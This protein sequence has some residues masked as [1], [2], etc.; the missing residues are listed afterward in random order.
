M[1]GPIAATRDLIVFDQRGI[2]L[3]HPLSCHRFELSA[4]GPALGQQIAECAAQIGP[5]RS[6]LHD[7]R[8]RRRHRGD[9]GSAG[10]YEK[11]V[12]Y[13]TSYGTKV[14]ERY[15]QT[16]PEPRSKRSCS[17]RSCPPTAPNR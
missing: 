13:G 3:S 2:G 15:A 8:H 17:T 14:A 9:H 5:T 1:L 7:R 12:L 4:G 10:G 6:R 16:Y 11:L